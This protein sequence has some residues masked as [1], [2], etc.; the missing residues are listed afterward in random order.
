MEAL[1]QE[2]WNGYQQNRSLAA[3]NAL[4]EWYLPWLQR[5]ATAMHRSLPRSA[6]L[7]VDDLVSDAMPGMIRALERFELDRGLKFTTFALLR[8][9][10]GIVDAL[11]ERDWV[12]R[13][14]RQRHGNGDA[15]VQVTTLDTQASDHSEGWQEATYDD[16][17]P[18]GDDF[19]RHVCRGLS[20]RDRLILML[21]WRLEMTM[22][23]VGDHLG[24]SESRV[25]QIMS[26]LFERLR[27]R[28]DLV[29]SVPSF[30]VPD[31]ADPQDEEIERMDSPD[32]KLTSLLDRLSNVKVEEID[33]E[34]SSLQERIASLTRLRHLVDPTTPDTSAAA[35]RKRRS[36]EEI[37]AIRDQIHTELKTTPSKI[38]PIAKRHGLSYA[39]VH[40]WITKSP[41]QFKIQP[42]GAYK[43]I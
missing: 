9:K 12:P 1:E 22:R 5:V 41:K 16:P 26:Q 24:L 20:C 28:T 34:I 15:I 38:G 42:D 23:D 32:T 36:P 27:E 14:E 7:D 18:R 40:G 2:L 21:Y 35:E 31:Q 39:V 37:A 25:S 17:D 33:A 3:R 43:A 19:W 30:T 8:V 4:I 10:G 13:L 6:G 29:A 11:R